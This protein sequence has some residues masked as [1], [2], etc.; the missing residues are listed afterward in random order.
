MGASGNAI[1]FLSSI[2][3]AQAGFFRGSVVKMRCPTHL[4]IGFLHPPAGTL[5]TLVINEIG[6]LVAQCDSGLEHHAIMYRSFFSTEY[7]WPPRSSGSVKTV[8][9]GV[10][11]RL[12]LSQLQSCESLDFQGVNLRNQFGM[13]GS[14]LS[15][16]PKLKTIT[17]RSLYKEE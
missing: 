16:R 7:M 4:K 3:A 9:L 1:D 13:T 2:S 15:N 10:D 11:S 17:S 12:I 5:S 8:Y 14:I 6:D